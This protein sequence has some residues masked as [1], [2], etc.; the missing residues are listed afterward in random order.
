MSRTTPSVST[1]QTKN[2]LLYTSYTGA[3]F[4]FVTEPFWCI[5]SKKLQ[6]TLLQ[7]GPIKHHTMAAIL[8]RVV[9]FETRP[10]AK[11]LQFM[12]RNKKKKRAV[13]W[14][15]HALDSNHARR[16]SLHYSYL[17]LCSC[18]LYTSRCV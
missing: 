9:Q 15:A 14:T 3:T 13:F 18:L 4:C 10:N 16:G 8:S 2:C 7:L 5:V 12:S 17:V 1:V 6:M 11:L